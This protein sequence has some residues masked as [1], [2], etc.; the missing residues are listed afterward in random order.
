MSPDLLPGEV[1]NLYEGDAELLVGEADVAEV[2]PA[3][4]HVWF[5][6]CVGLRV[7]AV[8][9]GM[10]DRLPS[11]DDPVLV[12]LPEITFRLDGLSPH[13]RLAT[14]T[15]TLSGSLS[16]VVAGDEAALLEHVEFGLVN[17]PTVSL[18]DDTV[19]VE[20]YGWSL[21]IAVVDDYGDRIAA[22]RAAG[23][24][25]VT[26]HAVLRR[27]DGS[28]FVWADVVGVLD[29]V[30]WV[31]S[32]VTG[33]R[34][35]VLFPTG[36]GR[37][38]QVV[39]CEWGNVRRSRFGGALS[40]CGDFQRAD[41]VRVLFP[42]LLDVWD[43]LSRRRRLTVALEFWLEAQ[44][45]SA[46]ET[47]LVAAVAGL[48]LMA[49]EWL[50]AEAG[51]DPD[52]VDRKKTAEWRL[53]SM[54]RLIGVPADVRSHMSDVRVAWPGSDGPKAVTD[55]RHRIVHPKDLDALLEVSHTGRHDVLRLATWYLELS[56]LRRLGYVGRYI[57]QVGPLPIFV[58]KGD[59]V[60][61]ASDTPTR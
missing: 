31:A 16:H 40:W 14:G 2:L 61:W 32:F 23:G 33:T 42:A 60:P 50:V 35:P 47:R 11:R 51:R 22:V 6:W 13:A 45:G 19:E 55:L 34:V 59:P 20:A 44:L 36:V 53:R 46:L 38:G 41:A 54:L 1:T 29:A 5:D 39:L 18:F 7:E 12:S 15:M 24:G 37:D 57:A 10:P 52:V 8:A 25:A 48:E 4:V 43:D 21:R 56:L 58:G 28:A 49:W 17:M 27:A 26:H 9:E 30:R 3:S